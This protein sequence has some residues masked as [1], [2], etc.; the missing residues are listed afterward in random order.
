MLLALCVYSTDEYDRVPTTEPCFES[1]RDTVDWT[2]HR[3][4]VSDN[5]SHQKMHDMYDRFQEQFP[6]EVIYN[7]HNIG[8]ANAVNKV[9]RLRVPGEHVLKADHDWVVHQT[10]WVDWM[11]DVFSRDPEIGICGLKR[12]DLEEC[13]WAEFE[14]YRSTLYM[15]PHEKGERWLSVERV[16]HVM[17]TCQAYNSALLDKMGYLYQGNWKYGFDD[18]LAAARA[19]VLGFKSVFLCGFDLDH[20]DPGAGPTA[21]HGGAKY[22]AWKHNVAGQAMGWFNHTRQQYLTGKEDPYY[23]GGFQK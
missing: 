15:L 21:P 7:G 20:I 4:V 3:L 14:G 11:E 13:P 18:S 5:G 8:T 19:Q 16:A 12:K 22:T 17:G 6:F 9:W 23:D 1:L 2:K 10:G